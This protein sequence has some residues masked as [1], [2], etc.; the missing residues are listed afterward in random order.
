MNPGVTGRWVA[1]LGVLSALLYVFASFVRYADQ[2]VS[3]N[4]LLRVS[5]VTPYVAARDYA[6]VLPRAASMR[7]NYL[8]ELFICLVYADCQGRPVS[9]VRLWDGLVAVLAVF[10]LYRTGCLC[11]HWVAALAACI[12]LAALPPAQWS[13]YAL[14]ILLVLWNFEALLYAAHRDNLLRWSLWSFS[15]LLLF[16]TG[17]FAEPLL[18]QTWMLALA[19]AWLIWRICARKLPQRASLATRDRHSGRDRGLWHQLQRDASLQRLTI[20]LV[21]VTITCF[22]LV[23]LSGIL[24]THLTLSAGPLVTMTAI[25]LG[26][27]AIT[28]SVLLTMT[29]FHRERGIMLERLMGGKLIW[30][31]NSPDSV[32]R[33]IALRTAG[34]ALALYSATACLFLPVFLKVHPGISPFILP[35]EERAVLFRLLAHSSALEWA[36]VLAPLACAGVALLGYY[37]RIVTRARLIGTVVAALLANVYLVQPQYALF[38]VPFS[39]L[40]TAAFAT[41]VIEV[42]Y[43][44]ASNLLWRH[45]R[46][47]EAA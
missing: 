15:L 41:G 8:N 27:S 37:L 13:P 31:L 21:A 7:F 29:M 17:V 25:S 20:L 9:S 39:I 26:L 35:C 24:L 44:L 6:G 36:V 16:C 14:Q 40:C 34:R 19:A 5:T 45:G 23:F 2:P 43:T 30:A 11:V 18:L 46:R 3:L 42:V 1:R 10:W 38:S 28:S 12:M 33:P 32:F 47:E 4:D 22:A